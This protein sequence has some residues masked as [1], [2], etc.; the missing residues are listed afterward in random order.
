MAAPEQEKLESY[1]ASVGG[2]E[3]PAIQLQEWLLIE[4]NRLVIATLVSVLT[5][6]L[7]YGL[8]AIDILAYVNDDSITRLAGGLTAGL[9]SLVTIVVSI[10]QLILSQEFS[11]AGTARDRLEDVTDFREDI[12]EATDVP[13]S[14]GAPSKLLELLAETVESRSQEL[15]DTVANH[16]NDEVRQLVTQYANRVQQSA[17]RMDET[18]EKA[19][20]GSFQAVSA[21]IRYDS[22]WQIYAGKHLAGQYR[23]ELSDETLEAF[24]GLIDELKLFEIAREHF[25]TTYLQRELTQFSRLTLFAGVPAILSAVGLAFLYADITGP[26][27][28]TSY[29]PIVTPA[30]V[31]VMVFP[32]GLMVS[33]VLRT[34]TVTRR[35]AS[36]GPML[37]QKDP[38]EGPFEASPHPEDD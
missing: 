9:F 14:P 22:A 35:T 38:D 30:L 5:F 34:A 20:F 24:D 7:F 4:G 27:I 33:Y 26:T 15:A 28:N 12:A 1:G 13:T 11:G 19:E 25:K 23:D 16:Q 8:G 2:Q 29:L 32:L 17:N 6:V 31:A 10:N 37:P 18:V 3:N 36:I 21:T